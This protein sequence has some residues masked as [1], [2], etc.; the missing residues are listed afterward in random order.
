MEELNKLDELLS[1]GFITESEYASRKA[2]LTGNITT[3]NVG[4]FIDLTQVTN[5]TSNNNPNNN[6]G[7]NISSS[8]ATDRIV[9]YKH[10]YV[11]TTIRGL[12]S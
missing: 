7:N 10:K 2:A 1:C 11:P 4:T 9:E 8:N 12:V 6:N 5:D 3:D